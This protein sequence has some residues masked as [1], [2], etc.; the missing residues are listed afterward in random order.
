MEKDM[1]VSVDDLFSVENNTT[2]YTLEEF[3]ANTKIVSGSDVK[4][5]EMLEGL[6]KGLNKELLTLKRDIY[7]GKEP[8]NC[9]TIDIATYKSIQ[10]GSFTII[11]DT[12]L[13]LINTETKTREYIKDIKTRL[14]EIN[15]MLLKHPDQNKFVL[16]WVSTLAFND[17]EKIWIYQQTLKGKFRTRPNPEV[18]EGYGF[19]SYFYI[20]VYQYEAMMA[21][22]TN[23]CEE[24][25]HQFKSLHEIKELKLFGDNQE[26]FVT[27]FTPRSK[28]T[29]TLAFD[30][31]TFKEPKNWVY[32]VNYTKDKDTCSRI[33][34]E[35]VSGGFQKELEHPPHPYPHLEDVSDEHF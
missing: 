21:D 19:D 26:R 2:Y 33:T 34:S 4:Y 12:I 13:L 1:I 5:Q 10:A 14:N 15:E 30:L 20:D 32:C 6:R 3:L 8:D 17:G 29:R 31:C 24:T 11:E 27:E 16:E 28:N 22:E 7:K 18:L 35:L 25:K 9:S 23:S